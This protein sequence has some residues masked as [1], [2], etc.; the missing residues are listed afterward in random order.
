MANGSFYGTEGNDFILRDYLSPGVTTDPAGLTGTEPGYRLDLIYGYGGDDIIEFGYQSDIAYGGEGNDIIDARLGGRPTTAFLVLVGGPGDDLLLGSDTRDWLDVG[1]PTQNPEEDAAGS[2]TLKGG[3][4]CDLYF[5]DS[6]GDKICEFDGEGDNDEVD[7]WLQF[8]VLP[9]NFEDLFMYSPNSTGIGNATNNFMFGYDSTV[10]IGGKGND[11]I[12]A[13]VLDKSLL[14]GTVSDRLGRNVLIGGDGDDELTI[15]DAYG[16]GTLRPSDDVLRGGAG[17]DRLTGD[18]GGDC[19]I[20]GKDSDVFVFFLV[21]DSLAGD[22]DFIKPGDGAKAF[23]G[24]GADAGDLIDLANM[25]ADATV[26]DIQTFTFGGTGRGCISLVD[27][28]S[29]T[30]V[31]GNVN[32]DTDFESSS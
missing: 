19:L 2:D 14:G 18:A 12:Y 24:A 10:L 6:V 31:R 30:L 27:R 9:K 28:G 17:N 16:D 20:G 21:T 3:K 15:Y 11:A 4:G 26:D 5:V 1:Y 29:D 32:D 13:T 8:F 22:L 23:E 25:D 7:T